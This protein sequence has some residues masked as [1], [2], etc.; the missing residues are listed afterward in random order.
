MRRNIR[1]GVGVGT[2]AVGLAWLLL[3]HTAGPAEE[4]KVS[5]IRIGVIASLFRN[6]P[7]PLMQVM[8]RPFKALLEMQ[9]GVTG[10][11]VAGGDAEHLGQKLKEDQVQ[12]GVFHGVE[13]AWARLKNP[14]LKPLILAVNGKRA[15]HA[16]LVVRKE[17]KATTCAD[18]K[19]KAV[20]L[21]QLTREH[22][23]LFLER[24]CVA[25]GQTPSQFFSQ[26][27]SPADTEDALDSVVNGQAQGA[28]VDQADLEG[29][30]KLKPGC[31]ARLRN[32]LESEAF[33]CAVVAYQPGSG[34]LDEATLHRLREGLIAA[35]SNARGQHLLEM[36]RIT[37]F[38]AVPDDY[39]EMLSTIAKAY[40]P[41]A[42][43]K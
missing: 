36:C 12:L 40:P 3:H 8:M 9:T 29:Y 5:T 22:C 42:A 1:S 41:P 16:L 2:V 18:L 30:R 14:S 37:A 31:A 13:F 6:T 10:Q 27:T 23:R 43:P 26:V 39:E 15:L 33:P 7:E 28:I 35:R 17:C 4:M 24:R 38:E 21:P 32:L 11:V 20:A 25:P 19:G 34:G